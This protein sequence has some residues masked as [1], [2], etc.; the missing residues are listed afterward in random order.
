MNKREK[1]IKELLKKQTELRAKMA[2]QVDN[3]EVFSNLENEYN[4]NKREIE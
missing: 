3:A 2:E 1:R 4:A